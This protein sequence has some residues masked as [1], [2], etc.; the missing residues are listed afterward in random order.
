MGVVVFVVLYSDS[1]SVL[2]WSMHIVYVM[3][4]K[5]VRLLKCVVY[6]CWLN[7]NDPWLNP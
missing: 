1:S 3:I 7:P 6:C 2:Y 4:R 5:L